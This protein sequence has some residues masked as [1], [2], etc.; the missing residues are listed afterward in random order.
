MPIGF[1][2]SGLSNFLFWIAPTKFLQGEPLFSMLFDQ[3][4]LAVSSGLVQGW[5]LMHG[6]PEQK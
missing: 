5:Y 6:E 4:Y 3:E 1:E 2:F